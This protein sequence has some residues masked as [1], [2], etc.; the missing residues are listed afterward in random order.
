MNMEAS[1]KSMTAAGMTRARYE[2]E[3][4]F[5]DGEAAARWNAECSQALPQRV[6]L[7]TLLVTTAGWAAAGGGLRVLPLLART[8]AR[9]ASGEESTARVAVADS[10]LRI[11]LD[12]APDWFAEPGAPEA[13]LLGFGLDWLPARSGAGRMLGLLR[14][15]RDELND[16]AIQ[17]LLQHGSTRRLV[18]Y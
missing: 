15:Q 11:G 4:R 10:R 13:L 17:A 18:F 5:A 12:L 3:I 16:A 6:E 9:L 8:M 7:G 2:L 14:L 1:K